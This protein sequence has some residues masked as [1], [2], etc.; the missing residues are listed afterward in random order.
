[1]R[2]RWQTISRLWEDNKATASRLNL[3]ENLD[4]YRKLSSQLEWQEKPDDRPIRIVQSQGGQPT[5]AVLQDDN[6]LVDEALYWITCRDMQEANYLLAIINSEALYGAVQPLRFTGQF[7]A[8]NLH[9]QLWK[10]PV[11]EFDGGNPLHRE[12]AEAGATAALGAVVRL[13]AL[14]EKRGGSV[15]VAVARRELRGWLWAGP[16]GAT[17]EHL[18]Q[19]LLQGANGWTIWP[20]E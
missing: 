1:M 12:V 8:R 17:V 7:G 18:V 15:S 13:A 2:W 9:K 11:P 4:H 19:S 20:T 3:L 14:R 6:A 5:A 16:Q 10:L